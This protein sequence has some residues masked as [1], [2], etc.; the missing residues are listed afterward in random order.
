[1]AHLATV[2]C[3]PDAH[4]NIRHTFVQQKTP[5]NTPWRQINKK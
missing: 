1:M 5:E 3:N 2:Y 4:K